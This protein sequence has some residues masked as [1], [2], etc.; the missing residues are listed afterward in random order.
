[1]LAKTRAPSR[2]M[3][4]KVLPSELLIPAVRYPLVTG[5]SEPW[6]LSRDVRELA[7][8]RKEN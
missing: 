5:D 6:V 1:M 8:G 2:G 7:T 4:E 3:G